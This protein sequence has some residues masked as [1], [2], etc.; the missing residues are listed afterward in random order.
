MVNRKGCTYFITCFLVWLALVLMI[1]GCLASCSPVKKATK[2]YNK[3]KEK[4]LPT[5]ALLS[6]ADWPC[7]KT[8]ADTVTNYLPGR[9]DTVTRDQIVTVDCPDTSRSATP[10]AVI[11]VPVK[12]PCA[13]PEK[14]PDTLYRYITQF[15]KDP[16]DSI[17]YTEQLQ[18]KD[19]QI[20]KV[21]AG[22]NTWRTIALV[23]GAIF[24]LY[25]ILSRIFRLF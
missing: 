13:C 5:V 7:G 1:F 19:K 14:Q 3:A 17:V 21:E 20:S 4:H 9:T 8:K 15:E 25:V 6:K 23:I 10:G 22:R 11:K 2:L 16:R 24:A 18:V 12:V